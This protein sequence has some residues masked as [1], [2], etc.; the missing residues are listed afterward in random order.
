[1]PH[2]PVQTEV[3]THANLEQV[4]NCSN[5]PYLD[6]VVPGSANQQGLC[7]RY[8]KPEWKGYKGF[9]GHHPE[10]MRIL[11]VEFNIPSSYVTNIVPPV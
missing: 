6:T 3:L 9:C 11:A 1:M 2:L 4:I 10:F 7:R 8:P 5:C